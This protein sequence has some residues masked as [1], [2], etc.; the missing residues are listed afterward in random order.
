MAVSEPLP[1]A[2]GL[3][4]MRRVLRLCLK[5]FASFST[6]LDKPEARQKRCRTFR[7]LHCHRSATCQFGHSFKQFEKIQSEVLLS[8]SNNA[9]S[10]LRIGASDNHGSW[11]SRKDGCGWTYFLEHMH[12]LRIDISS[13]EKKVWQGRVA[14]RSFLSVTPSERW[15]CRLSRCVCRHRFL[16]EPGP[17]PMATDIQLRKFGLA[18]SEREGAP[19]TRRSVRARKN[20]CRGRILSCKPTGR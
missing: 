8:N 17:R 14:R 12:P 10:S 3:L 9:G 19:F 4:V 5:S 18:I 1:V 16:A 13:G 20:R 6:L 7:L 11:R 15:Q 2:A